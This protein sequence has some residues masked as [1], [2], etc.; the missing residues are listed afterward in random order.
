M[1]FSLGQLLWR[2]S[3]LVFCDMPIGSVSVAAGR[4]ER[5]DWTTTNRCA[6]LGQLLALSQLV[7]ALFVEDLRG[8]LVIHDLELLVRVVG[9]LLSIADTGILHE[10]DLL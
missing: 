4:D 3:P 8:D 10:V 2:K 1:R 6:N 7:T 5:A 9:K